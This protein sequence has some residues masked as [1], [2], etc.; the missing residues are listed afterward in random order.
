[1]PAAPQ[2]Q[3]LEVVKQKVMEIDERYEG[4][5][6]ELVAAL[7]DILSLERNRP[8]NIKQQVSRRI[9]ALGEILVA[10]KGRTE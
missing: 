9:T 5:R 10:K 4:Y 8:H 1:M 6:A 2:R 3:A 7:H